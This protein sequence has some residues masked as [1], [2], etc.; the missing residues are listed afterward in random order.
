MQKK[1]KIKIVRCVCVWW[2]QKIRNITDHHSDSD[3]CNKTA[4]GHNCS[5]KR[6]VQQRHFN[7]FRVLFV[8]FF[9]V[10]DLRWIWYGKKKNRNVTMPCPDD[11]EEYKIPIYWCT[12]HYLILR[13]AVF[14]WNFI[15]TSDLLLLLYKSG[16]WQGRLHLFNLVRRWFRRKNER[17]SHTAIACT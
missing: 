5:I 1:I 11:A 2:Y 6:Y 9:F 16:K 10:Y 13:I 8:R 14:Q 17:L 4:R 15:R 7:Q 3:N 12:Q